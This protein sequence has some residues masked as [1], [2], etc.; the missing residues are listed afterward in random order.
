MQGSQQGIV[1]QELLASRYLGKRVRLSADIK[2]QA[3]TGSAFMYMGALV[4]RERGAIAFSS[5]PNSVTG[6]TA[7]QRLSLELDVP[8]TAKLIYF[9]LTAAGSDEIWL[10]NVSFAPVN[11]GKSNDR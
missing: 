3:L 11:T 10:A 1:V 9:G 8:R 2:S 5:M 6:T 4:Q 7:W